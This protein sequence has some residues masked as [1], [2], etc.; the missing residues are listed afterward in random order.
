MAYRDYYTILG[1]PQG[2]TEQEIK[3]AYRKLARQLHPDL[4]PGNKKAEEKFKEVNEAYEIL[5]D[6]DK[7]RQY[8]LYGRWQQEGGRSTSASPGT[9]AGFGGIGNDFDFSNFGN[10][11]EF[12]DFLMGS[13]RT[14]NAPPSPGATKG[15]PMEMTAELS[16]EE[17]FTGVRKR[18]RTTQGKVIEVSFPRGVRT[19]SRI[20][21]SGE[22]Q[23]GSGGT[24]D[25]ILTVKLA[26]HPYYT[27]DGD[28]VLLELPLTPAE[29]V[30]GGPIEVPTLEGKVRIN[31]PRNTTSG[32]ILR[33]AGKGLKQVKGSNRGDQLIKVR[34]EVPTRPSEA[35]R[36]LYEQ[37]AKIEAP[38]IRSHLV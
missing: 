33:L 34:I 21:V 10:F 15:E 17:S 7:R 13:R 4:N 26:D 9:G 27:I 30:V 38:T 12:I 16:L 2:S 3:T 36:E 23:V 25:L 6:A 24:G 31:I 19:G 22:G 20:R 5:S 28:D 37:L 18:Y 11:E 8:D 1:I 14:G 35:E 32:R 29:A